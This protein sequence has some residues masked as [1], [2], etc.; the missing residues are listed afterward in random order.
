[1]KKR[2][3]KEKQGI[4][5]AATAMVVLLPLEWPAQMWLVSEEDEGLTFCDLPVINCLT[6]EDD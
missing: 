4:W 6:K 5:G 3:E 2:K 1:L